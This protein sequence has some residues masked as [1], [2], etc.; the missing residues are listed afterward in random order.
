MVYIFALIFC[1]VKRLIR[2]FALSKK[3]F[4]GLL[5]TYLFFFC[6]LPLG[7]NKPVGIEL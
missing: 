3:R 1:K 2:N 4:N 6:T 7:K 5:T